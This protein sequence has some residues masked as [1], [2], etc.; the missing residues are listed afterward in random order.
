MIFRFDDFSVDA[1]TS[2][3]HRGE[4][5][6]VASRRLIGVLVELISAEGR[7]V[8]KEQLMAAVW[9]D[10]FVSEASL[11]KAVSDLRRVFIAQGARSYILTIHGTGYRFAGASKETLSFSRDIDQGPQRAGSAVRIGVFPFDISGWPRGERL[12]L[13]LARQLAAKLIWL[14]GASVQPPTMISERVRAKQE[15]VQ[16][17]RELGITHAVFGSIHRG[18]SG[19]AVSVV[20]SRMSEG[21]IVWAMTARE[22]CNDRSTLIEQ[23]VASIF[24]YLPKRLN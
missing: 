10:R 13:S 5:M 3:L 4:E 17:A 22:Q 12:S 7:T 2:E 11:A 16:I 8:S 14:I 20:I 9:G 19:S 18:A 21:R 6:V 1:T 15:T 24:K 23:I